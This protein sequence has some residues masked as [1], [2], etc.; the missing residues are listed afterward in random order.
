MLPHVDDF[1]TVHNLESLEQLSA[2]FSNLGSR[3]ERSVTQWL[4]MLRS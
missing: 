1:R 4:P 2:V 3:Q